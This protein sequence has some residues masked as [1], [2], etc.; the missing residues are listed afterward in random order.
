MLVA[1]SISNTVYTDTLGM[2][3]KMSFPIIGYL[4]YLLKVQH[5]PADV[6]SPKCNQYKSTDCSFLLSTSPFDSKCCLKAT[7]MALLAVLRLK[8]E[9]DLV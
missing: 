8:T 4:L 3:G 7:G 2:L 1:V 6:P 5:N 9:I